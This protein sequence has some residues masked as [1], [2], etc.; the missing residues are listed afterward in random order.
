MCHIWKQKLD[1]QISPAELDTALNNRLYSEVRTVGVNGG[2]PTLRKDLPEL[3]E[4]LFRRM[5]RLKTVSLITN[6]FVPGKVIERIRETGE[7]INR[8]GGKFDVMV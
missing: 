3:V 4:I 8:L 5:P 7:I 1:Y 6:G 2:E